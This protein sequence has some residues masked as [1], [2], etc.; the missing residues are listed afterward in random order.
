MDKRDNINLTIPQQV[1]MVQGKLRNKDESLSLTNE[2]TEISTTSDDGRKEV[3]RCI[4][5]L[6]STLVLTSCQVPVRHANAERAVHTLRSSNF[7]FYEAVWNVAKTCTG[8]IAL[9]K[10]FYWI[11]GAPSS[12]DVSNPSADRRHRRF[13]AWVDIVAQDGSEWI[14]V[15]TLTEKRILFDLAKAGWDE[16]SSADDQDGG[17]DEPEGLLK[18]AEALAKT[19]RATRIRYRHPKVRIVLPKIKRGGAQEVASLIDQINSLG[20]TVQTTEDLQEN[21]PIKSVLKAMTVDPFATITSRINIDCTILLALVSDLSHGNVE[22][23]DWHH[24]S[25]LRQIEMEKQDHMLPNSLWPACGSKPMVCTKEAA[26]RM[27]EIVD[28]IG[29]QTEKR[30]TDCL[31]RTH[32]SAEWS[33]EERIQ[34]FQELSLYSV[35]PEWNLPIDVV[36]V[37][38]CAIKSRLPPISTAVIRQLSPIN[39]SVFL[40][41]W[42]SRQTTLSSN[43]TV[44]KDIELAIEVNRIGE[45][46][47]GPDIWLCPTARSLV[48]KEKTRRGWDK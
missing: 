39:Q 36:E 26:S 30:R 17:E 14:K 25:I 48:G 3:S 11:S 27:H 23:R 29:T 46:D 35:P 12:G 45:Y 6:R 41:G 10:R 7:P 22:E 28:L 32:V 33:R 15:S 13:N 37:D 1:L 2:E 47:Q 4:P 19:A 16:D 9:K 8:V 5:K 20:I 34:G 40:Y 31:M 43:R 18:Q 24:R 42:D 21:R 38:L 44:A